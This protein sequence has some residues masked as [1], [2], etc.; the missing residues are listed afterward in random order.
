[1]QVGEQ[2]LAFAQ[3][4]RSTA[5]GSLTFTIMSALAKTSSAV[6]MIL[7]PAAT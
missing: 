5:C 6:S 4:L 2:H 1:V 3:R 7:A